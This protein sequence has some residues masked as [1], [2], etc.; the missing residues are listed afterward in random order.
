MF[1][2]VGVMLGFIVILYR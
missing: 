1:A 2:Y